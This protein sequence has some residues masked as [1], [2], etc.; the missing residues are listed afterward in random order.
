LASGPSMVSVYQSLKSVLF[1][2]SAFL[3]YSRIVLLSC[4][5]EFGN[6][7]RARESH[8]I[9][10]SSRSISSSCPHTH[11]ISIRSPIPKRTDMIL[12][13][14]YFFSVTKN[15]TSSLPCSGMIWIYCFHFFS[16]TRARSDSRD[17][18]TSESIST[19]A[20]LPP[21]HLFVMRALT[22]SQCT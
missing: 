6:S 7:V 4:I 19:S 1:L 12:F 3:A 16:T 5:T 9:S 17:L 13:S 2:R 18:D 8:R 14:S 20:I 22:L 11:N 21:S 10:R 15:H